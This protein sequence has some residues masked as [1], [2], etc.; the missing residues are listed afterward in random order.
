MNKHFFHHHQM[1]FSIP[2]KK[3]SIF[4]III[5]S[6]MGFSGITGLL[7]TLYSCVYF[8]L[9]ERSLRTGIYFLIAVLAFAVISLFGW[10]AYHAI[11]QR[12]HP[13]EYCIGFT[14]ENFINKLGKTLFS[15]PLESIQS[16]SLSKYDGSIVK[17]I[18]LNYSKDGGDKKFWISVNDLDTRYSPEEIIHILNVELNKL[19]S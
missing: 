14:K 15:F 18:E 11:Y 16:I 9:I 7:F 1:V 13:K 8:F 10:M 2:A 19:R 3:P 17:Y 5:L 6:L 4:Y 12:R